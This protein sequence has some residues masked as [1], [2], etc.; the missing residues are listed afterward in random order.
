M[1]MLR[2]LFLSLLFLVGIVHSLS[3]PLIASAAPRN[4]IGIG[5]VYLQINDE[6]IFGGGVFVTYTI[7][8]PDADPAKGNF[9]YSKSYLN[10]AHCG[11][12]GSADPCIANVQL[13][14]GNDDNGN[15][16]P[17]LKY[18]EAYQIKYTVRHH[19]GQ[20]IDQGGTI[21]ARND[22]AARTLRGAV[23]ARPGDDL[24]QADYKWTAPPEGMPSLKL[25]PSNVLYKDQPGI[26]LTIQNVAPLAKNV[27]QPAEYAITVSNDMGSNPRIYKTS[28]FMVN[29]SNNGCDFSRPYQPKNELNLQCSAAASPTPY[30]ILDV[31][32]NQVWNDFPALDRDV[33]YKVDLQVYPTSKGTDSSTKYY[34]TTITVKSANARPNPLQLSFRDSRG[35]SGKFPLNNIP[36]SITIRTEGATAGHSYKFTIH[37]SSGFPLTIRDIQ[38]TGNIVEVGFNP[39][40]DCN[41]K[42]CYKATGQFPVA[43]VDQNDPATVG[44]KN[45]EVIDDPTPTGKGKGG[46][47]DCQNAPKGCSS[48]A[49]VACDTDSKVAPDPKN[50]IDP[51]SLPPNRRGVYT[52]IG[53]VPTEPVALVQSLV[54]FSSAMGGGIA[55][56]LMAWGALQMIASA[57]NPENLK[58]GHDQFINAV[59][60]LLVIILAV[61]LMQIIGVDILQIP[62][63][64]K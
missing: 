57:G 44:D 4:K 28:R 2:F 24:G 16:P 63:F 26:K 33:T 29:G 19:I 53:C 49:G 36:N 12:N 15:P 1:S 13:P 5:Y 10:D 60:G 18:G 55:L 61:V 3:S 38:A 37:N 56:L 42:P 8:G 43:V 25:E 51:N 45:I 17:T 40:N 41:I 50:P 31:F 27:S 14:D 58:K 30:N 20:L 64:G 48:A 23:S 52:A 39:Q 54:R 46:I 21:T 34:Q 35:G 22:F 59:I 62:G 47:V 9:T 6:Y 32:F 7:T 11:I